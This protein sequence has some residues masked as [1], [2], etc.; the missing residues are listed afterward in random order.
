MEAKLHLFF[1]QTGIITIYRTLNEVRYMAEIKHGNNKFYVGDET[2]PDAEM[3][4]TMNDDV[5]TIT[6]TG[7]DPS[8]RG[9]GVG[10]QLVHA[11]LE[12]A[13]ENDL[14]IDAQCWFAKAFIEYTDDKDILVNK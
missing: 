14:K 6:H 5:M 7:V 8:L 12:Y 4:Y 1:T 2:K 9:Q 13:K 10:N 11:G 3:D